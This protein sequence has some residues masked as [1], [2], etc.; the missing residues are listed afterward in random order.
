MRRF[1]VSSGTQ[2]RVVAYSPLG[3]RIYALVERGRGPRARAWTLATG[4]EVR[5]DRFPR[6]ADSLAVARSADRIAA[7]SEGEFHVFSRR[8]DFHRPAH[9]DRG[10]VECVT[11]LADDGSVLAWSHGFIPP[12]GDMQ[13]QISLQRLDE[14]GS[15]LDLR[16]LNL[17]CDLD[18]SSDGSLLV[19]SG[20]GG[21]T[22]WHLGR[23][24]SILARALHGAHSARFGPDE[25]SLIVSANA[26]VTVWDI[27]GGTQ[28]FS[29]VGHQLAVRCLALSPDRRILASGGLDRTIRFWDLAAG[30]SLR[31]YDWHIGPVH[32][33]AFSPDGLTCAAGGESGE[34][35][36]W[37][38]ED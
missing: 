31:T 38:V 22:I 36:M 12:T 20:I 10:N 14:T 34:V 18:F 28:R 24:E 7:G 35:V 19:S 13:S 25:R 3:D 37:D 32:S 30:E 16:T 4:K 6:D 21:F 27:V 2:V 33:L 5:G 9:F 17:T 15:R 1:R 11:A 26:F 23:Q 29:L 8:G